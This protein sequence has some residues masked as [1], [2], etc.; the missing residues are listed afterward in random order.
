MT[1]RRVVWG[2]GLVACL[3]PGLARAQLG[4]I[5]G[6]GGTIREDVSSNLSYNGLGYNVLAGFTFTAPFLPVSIRLDGMYNQFSSPLSV[7]Q[8]QI[9][10]ATVNAQY[11]IPF[12]LP[13]IHPYLVGGGGYYHLTSRYF[14]PASGPAPAS[15]AW[16]PFQGFGVNGGA[17]LRTGYGRMGFF[18]EWRYDYVFAGGP[19][20]PANHTTYAPFTFG[21]MF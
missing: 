2:A 13:I 5:M 17:G 8:A 16:A 19:H 18:G 7:H 11:S 15:W 6:G 9:Y 3:V 12:P 10:S 21:V 1:M 14:N 4:V 20:N